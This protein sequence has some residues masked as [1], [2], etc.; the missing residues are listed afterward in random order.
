YVGYVN[1]GIASAGKSIYVENSIIHSECTAKERV[2]CKQGNIIG[3]TTSAGESIEAKD[4]GNRLSTKTEIS[5]G[6]DKSMLEQ[7]QRLIE[8]KKELEKTF[9]K[10]IIISDKIKKKKKK[11]IKRKKKKKKK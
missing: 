3:G 2:H 10:Y 8:E 4:I 6:F 1:Q 11:E 5:F 9:K 7:E